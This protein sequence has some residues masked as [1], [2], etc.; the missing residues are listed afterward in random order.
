MLTPQYYLLSE[1]PKKKDLLSFGDF[2]ISDLEIFGVPNLSIYLF[3]LL[4]E[5]W[6]GVEEVF[7]IWKHWYGKSLNKDAT[8]YLLQIY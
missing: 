8:L 7:L 6:V 3:P 4:D 5:L 2:Y 1:I